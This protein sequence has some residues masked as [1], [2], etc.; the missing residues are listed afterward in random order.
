MLT[1]LLFLLQLQFLGPPS[2]AAGSDPSIC[3]AIVEGSYLAALHQ[4]HEQKEEHELIAWVEKEINRQPKDPI[5]KLPAVRFSSKREAATFLRSRTLA[6]LF[7]YAFWKDSASSILLDDQSKQIRLAQ[8]IIETF[9]AITPFFPSESSCAHWMVGGLNGLNAK[10][11]A[12][13]EGELIKVK[14]VLLNAWALKRWDWSSEDLK[15]FE[16]IFDTSL[17]GFF[18]ADNPNGSYEKKFAIWSL[19]D[20]PAALR[21]LSY[22]RKKIIFDRWLSLVLNE[23]YSLQDF[24]V[25]SAAWERS[26]SKTF[27]FWLTSKLDLN[28]LNL[29]FKAEKPSTIDSFAIRVI[30]ALHFKLISRTQEAKAWVYTELSRRGA[31]SLTTFIGRMLWVELRGIAPQEFRFLWTALVT[32][33]PTSTQAHYFNYLRELGGGAKS[34]CNPLFTIDCLISAMKETGVLGV[35]KSLFLEE[36]LRKHLYFEEALG[37]IGRAFADLTP[38]ELSELRNERGSRQVEEEMERLRQSLSYTGKKLTQ[39][40]AASYRNVIFSTFNLA[41]ADA[42]ARLRQLALD[43]E[44]SLQDSHRLKEIYR[45]LRLQA[46]NQPSAELLRDLISFQTLLDDTS[47]DF[48]L[49]KRQLTQ[50][51][52]Q[53]SA[54]IDSIKG[55]LSII[56]YPA[57][58][59]ALGNEGN[60]AKSI[61]HRVDK[62]LARL[63]ELSSLKISAKTNSQKV[64]LDQEASNL[65]IQLYDAFLNVDLDTVSGL[66]D[67][68]PWAKMLLK[69][70]AAE[71]YVS[72][73]EVALY[74]RHSFIHTT[75]RSLGEFLVALE[76]RLLAKVQGEL[77]PLG[78]KLSEDVLESLVRQTSLRGLSKAVSAFGSWKQ[79]NLSFEGESYPVIVLSEGTI[80]APLADGQVELRE[81]VPLEPIFFKALFLER[82][83][84]LSHHVVM[85]MRALK[86]PIIVL[87]GDAKRRL[88]ER[89]RELAGQNVQVKATQS[90]VTLRVSDATEGVALQAYLPLPAAI[91]GPLGPKGLALT[92]LSQR[93]FYAA[94]IAPF[95]SVPANSSKMEWLQWIRNLRKEF[96]KESHWHFRSDF[97][98]E[99]GDVWN[100]A[101][102]FKSIPFVPVKIQKDVMSAIEAVNASFKEAPLVEI[103]GQHPLEAGHQTKV[104][105]H[106]S[107]KAS[108]SGVLLIT[109]TKTR[110]ELHQGTGG[111]VES[112]DQPETW[113]GG[114]RGKLSLISL[115]ARQNSIL[116]KSKDLIEIRKLADQIRIDFPPDEGGWDIEFGVEGSGKVWIHQMRKAF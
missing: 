68:V 81:Q 110:I 85:K 22:A 1:A 20:F 23:G 61:L 77:S 71:G 91:E 105:A 17:D 74:L 4:Q 39:W 31:T 106:A 9:K 67:R 14:D 48:G 53:T 12:F 45:P 93:P 55:Y 109:P 95:V 92:E 79:T 24:F 98:I 99:D 40:N 19:P 47:V 57:E 36:T 25:G 96:P 101:G 51:Q 5:T 113:M 63:Q 88:Q 114:L 42:I 112:T 30:L 66:K 21:K 7:S 94:H 116:A 43:L 2:Y 6:R 50:A 54:L 82:I 107:R 3:R 83:P 33:Q 34:A 38:R 41:S 115:Q 84:S 90:E 52:R 70:L 44:E 13:G 108:Y 76:E 59:A 58:R 97:D 37:Q 15:I 102:V 29:G 80:Q 49:T 32:A 18:E 103:F 27:I 86:R 111:V 46:H 8:L 26:D 10:S 65:G 100:A 72:Q 60:W 56:Q 11:E 28:E 62:V 35:R 69:N 75:L 16:T 89:L 104:L 78:P 87:R 64:I 73:E